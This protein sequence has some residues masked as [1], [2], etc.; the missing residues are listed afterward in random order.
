MAVA[1]FD[2]EHFHIQGIDDAIQELKRDAE[3]AG[4]L[5][6]REMLDR[7]YLVEEQANELRQYYCI[8]LGNALLE[9]KKDVKAVLFGMASAEQLR[10]DSRRVRGEVE[11]CVY[12][13]DTLP[14]IRSLTL[15]RYPYDEKVRARA[16]NAVDRLYP[17][18]PLHRAPPSLAQTVAEHAAYVQRLR[19]PEPPEVVALARI[20]AQALGRL[21]AAGGPSAAQRPLTQQRILTPEAVVAGSSMDPGRYLRFLHICSEPMKLEAIWFAERIPLDRYSY[22]VYVGHMRYGESPLSRHRVDTGHVAAVQHPGYAIEVRVFLRDQEPFPLSPV[23]VSF[24][25]SSPQKDPR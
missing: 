3:I 16:K 2:M 5:D 7:I 24:V 15:S 25:T 18:E 9:G 14:F 11:A 8:K 17:P 23:P 4:K 12:L 10:E 1:R 19:Q 21:Q 13:E 20:T 22:E 6:K